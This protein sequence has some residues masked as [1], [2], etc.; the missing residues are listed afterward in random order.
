MRKY[1]IETYKRYKEDTEKSIKSLPKVIDYKEYTR[2][3]LII[4]FLP[5]VEKLSKK[6]STSAQ[7]SGVMNIS[8]LIQEGNIGLILAVDKINWQLFDL[9]PDKERTM[10]SF[11]SKRIRGAIRR[12][13]NINRGSIRIPEHK[14]NEL[15]RNPDE[16]EDLVKMFFNSVFLSSEDYQ[17]FDVKNSEGDN[18]K[19]SNIDIEDNSESN[20]SEI[21]NIYLTG[22]IKRHLTGKEYDV[23]RMSYGLDCEKHSAKR[24][25]DKLG[26]QGTSAYVRVSQ[27]KRQ[28]VD[29]LINTIDHSQILDYL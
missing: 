12:S 7:A 6:F 22:L 28:A 3:Q 8:D 19:K 25:A 16:N 5:L 4:E 1:N 2:D 21:L 14:I 20:N 23:L 13:I 10:Y 29:K 9:S 17:S 15:R 24:I 26:L 27:L 18:E 11:L